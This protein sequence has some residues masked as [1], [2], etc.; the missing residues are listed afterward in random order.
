MVGLLHQ[1]DWKITLKLQFENRFS[2]VLAF[3][4]FITNCQCG[5]VDKTRFISDL[6]G[7]LYHPL[8]LSGMSC[9]DKNIYDHYSVANLYHE[10]KI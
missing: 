7:V 9:A 4:H 1:F 6:Q 3:C 8:E 2:E 5:I 10:Y